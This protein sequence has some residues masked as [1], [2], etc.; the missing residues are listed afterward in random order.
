[1]KILYLFTAIEQLV[2]TVITALSLSLSGASSCEITVNPKNPEGLITSFSVVSDTHVETT[3]SDNY[4]QF[5]DI[6]NGLKSCGSEAAVFL[7]DNTMNGQYLE[8]VLFYSAVKKVAPADKILV[9]LGNHDV[10]N[11]KGNYNKLCKRFL[12][13]N[14]GYLDNSSEKPY[15]YRVISGCYMIFLASEDLSVHSSVI[16]EE[17]YNW[18]SSLLLEAS[19]Q[20]API[21]VF[22]HHTINQFEGERED[23]I[24]DLLA[25]YEN[26]I[27]FNGHT[28]WQLDEYS[29]STRNGVRTVYLPCVKGAGYPAG[30]GIVVEVYA[31]EVIIRCRN[32]IDGTWLEIPEQ[33]YSFN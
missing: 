17:Q 19:S 29:F 1:M 30:D 3:A 12:R 23:D 7:G 5:I 31:S 15:Y 26:L 18:L 13:F 2:L 21:F 24:V 28:H 14:S 20:N 22:N 10:G 6:L 11:G 25:G 9:A 16:S 27:Y 4:N 33:V 32:F 8:S